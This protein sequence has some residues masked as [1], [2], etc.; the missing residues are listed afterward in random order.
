MLV[1]QL[2]QADQS[3]EQA[4]CTFQ[5]FAEDGAD[6]GWQAGVEDIV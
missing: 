6:R 2:C 3:G 4:G 5:W 1:V